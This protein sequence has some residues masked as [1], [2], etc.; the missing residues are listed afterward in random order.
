RGAY[1]LLD[2]ST[3]TPDVILVATGSEVQ[4]AVAAREQLEADGVGARVVSAPCLE[5]F[6]EQDADYRESVLPAAV[7]ARVSVEAGIAMPWYR[8][9]G[10]AGRAVSLEHFGASADAK[11]LFREFGFT[12]EAVVA[13]ARESIAAAA[14][15]AAP[16][17]APVP[18]DT[19]TGDQQA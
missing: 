3:E 4:Y 6:D 17:H 12:P 7:R 18:H 14:G 9:L 11:T 5:W 2:S 16:G 13:A 1:V 8:Y 15:G 10:D 19:G